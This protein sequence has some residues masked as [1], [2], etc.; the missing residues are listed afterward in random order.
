MSHEWIFALN[1]PKI[2]ISTD[3]KIQIKQPQ[4]DV[5]IYIYIYI[6]YTVWMLKLAVI[7][8]SK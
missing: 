4:Y 8:F 1:I 6:S 3:I 7:I 2:L 5:Y